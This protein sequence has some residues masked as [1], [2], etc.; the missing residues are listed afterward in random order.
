MIVHQWKG[1]FSTILSLLLLM[2]CT[3][4]LEANRNQQCGKSLQ[5]TLKLT[6]LI[7]KQSVE[8]IKTYKVSVGNSSDLFCRASLNNIPNPK[9]SG[10]E[11]SERIVSIYTKLQAFFPHFKRV[12]MQQADLQPPTSP[13]LTELTQVD[14]RSRNLL[15]LIKSFYQNFFPNLPLPDPAGGTT[16]LPPAQNIF[17]QKVYG[18]VVLKTFKDFLLNVS[19]EV[20]FLKNKVCRTQVNMLL[21]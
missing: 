14:N 3:T 9:I 20:R 17:Q 21:Y 18:C 5:Q 16:T 7:Q 11:P 15:A 10:M 12:Y 4:T 8:L 19:R 13:L 6:R 2:D 1:P